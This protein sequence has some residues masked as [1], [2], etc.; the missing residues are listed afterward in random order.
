M[1]PGPER[2]RSAIRVPG[3]RGRGNAA[4]GGWSR[5]R[6]LQRRRASAGPAG[7]GAVVGQRPPAAGPEWS[8]GGGRTSGSTR[9]RLCRGGVR[10]CGENGALHAQHRRG[11]GWTGQRARIGNPGNPNA[12]CASPA[13]LGQH[14]RDAVARRQLLVRHSAV[15]GR[16]GAADD[17]SQLQCEVRGPHAGRELPVAGSVRYTPRCG[18]VH[19][20]VDSSRRMA[21]GGS[22]AA[23][24]C[25]VVAAPPAAPR[26][27]GRDQEPG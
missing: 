12:S 18:D 14:H 1:T 8:A 21:S 11:P 5:P 19:R 23:R 24:A 10:D 22:P 9:R 17:T 15:L 3:Q 4:Q 27:R 16:S 25:A 20:P 7:A 6:T 13:P 2:A 26:W